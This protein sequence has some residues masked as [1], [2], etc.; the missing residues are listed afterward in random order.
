MEDYVLCNCCIDYRTKVLEIDFK[1]WQEHSLENGR[2]ELKRN[3]ILSLALK[4]TESSRHSV[5]RKYCRLTPMLSA[6]TDPTM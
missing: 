4:S 2:E 6:C 1:K 3:L 5:W